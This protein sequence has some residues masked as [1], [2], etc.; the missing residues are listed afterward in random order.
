MPSG[1]F[2]VS[3]SIENSFRNEKVKGMFDVDMSEVKKE[4]IVDIP[5][6]DRSWNV[7]L[8]VGGSGTGKTTIAKHI[9]KNGYQFF[10][11]Y[12]WSKQS[13]IDNFPS[14]FTPKE[15]TEALSKVGFSS[16]PDW[17]KPFSALSN[18]QQMRAELARLMLDADQ[19]V[20]YDEFTSVVDRQVAKIG[21]YAISKYIKKYDKKFIAV[22]C[23]KDI[24]EWLEADWVYD[25]DK[26]EFQWV[27]LR[28]P[29]IKVNIKK[30]K[31]FE[32]KM[33]SQFHYLTSAH[34]NSAHKYIAEINGE[35]VAWCS[36]M[37]FPHPK[38]KNIKKLHRAVVKP[39]YQGIGLGSI[40]IKKICEMY[41]NKGFRVVISLSAPALI[42]SMQRD[43]SWRMT[44]KPGYTSKTSKKGLLRGTTAAKRLTASFEYIA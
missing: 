39:D 11:G 36:I 24:F 41:I 42:N 26:N 2:V 38:V 34:N 37:H 17:L 23:H 29:E 12:E 8:I 5:I 33:F 21:S 15:I 40:F 30:A 13:V 35:P 20:I 7:G 14:K 32:W 18:G 4:F 25:T 28:R 6:D 27:Y 44:R 3:A 10:A 9:F 43:K 19:P 22:S 16:P 1:K 31:Q